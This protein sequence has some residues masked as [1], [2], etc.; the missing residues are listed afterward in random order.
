MSDLPRRHVLTGL[1]SLPLAAVLV[2]DVGREGRQRGVDADGFAA[3]VAGARHPILAAGGVADRS[4]LEALA[5]VGAAGVV[6]GMALYT[7]R[8]EPADALELEQQ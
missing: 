3:L 4:D 5:G 6:L 8:L 1:A 2:T 7:G